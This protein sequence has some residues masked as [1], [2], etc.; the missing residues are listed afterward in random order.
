MAHI[1]VVFSPQNQSRSPSSKLDHLYF[2]FVGHLQKWRCRSESPTPLAGLEK[3]GVVA[4]RKHIN[5]KLYLSYRVL[6]I[7]NHYP[8]T[9]VILQIIQSRN[10]VWPWSVSVGCYSWN[11]GFYGIKGSYLEKAEILCSAS[12][13]YSHCLAEIS[14]NTVKNKQQPFLCC[15]CQSCQ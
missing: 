3:W 1:V 2:P 11:P 14:F 13:S 9:R 4:R 6:S 15:F 8:K 7:K 10:K 12:Y 5:L